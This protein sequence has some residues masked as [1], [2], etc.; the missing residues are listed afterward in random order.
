M[1]SLRN[2]NCKDMY[3]DLFH[4]LLQKAETLYGKR[5]T[6]FIIDGVE[7]TT[8]NQPDIHFPYYDNHVIIRITEICRNDIDFATF[9]IAHE[10]IHCLCPNSPKIVTYLEE[11]LAVHFQLECTNNIRLNSDA[12]KYRKAVKLLENLLVYDNDTIR[13]SRIIEPNISK[14]TG[15]I[16]LSICPQ[17]DKYLVSSLTALFYDQ[18]V[19]YD[20]K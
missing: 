11:G 19:Q 7:I 2:Q 3:D 17:I 5:N 14:I 12:Y 9:Q 16:L 8:S 15:D 6:D 13:K 1:L 10:V 18:Q 4:E 20:H